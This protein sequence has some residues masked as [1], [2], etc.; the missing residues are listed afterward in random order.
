MSTRPRGSG[1]Q[2]AGG[3][4][5]P[6]LFLST[7]GHE[8]RGPLTALKG[9]LDL[10]R[11]RLAR[12]GAREE[13]LRELDRVMGPVERLAHQI[14]I[15]LDAAHLL[16]GR[17]ALNAEET[18]LAA[19]IRRAVEHV[20]GGESRPLIACELPAAPLVGR[21]DATALGRV[22]GA[23][24]FNALKY[25]R[26]ERPVLVRATHDGA[27]ARVEVVDEGLGVPEGER[28]AIFEFGRHGSNA[29]KFAGAGLGLYVAREVIR[30]HGGAIEVDPRPGRGSVFWFTLPLPA[31]PPPD[32]P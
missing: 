2:P 13:Q 25:S 15:V 21:W 9:R 30:R 23:L 20:Q 14:D 17:F 8:M 24:L 22:L 12:G 29:A 4:L 11:R 16:Q 18:D 6:T 28:E 5:D 31:A 3:D 27:T 7:L 32:D 1:A 19:V 26:Y 10:M